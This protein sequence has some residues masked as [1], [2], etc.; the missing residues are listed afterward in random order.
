MILAREEISASAL[1][2]VLGYLAQRTNVCAKVIDRD[3]R[4]VAV[5]RRGLELLESEAR[6]VCGQIWAQFWSGEDH[7]SA[8][9]A[10]EC[11][12]GGKPNEFV[13]TFRSGNHT[14]VWE[15]EALPLEWERGTVSKVLVLST[16]L[17][18]PVEQRDP[19]HTHPDADFIA[20]LSET[21]HAL[22]NMSSVSTSG[23]N[24]LR[25]GV[26]P[27]RA[28]YLADALEDAGRRA[29]DA[30]QELAAILGKDKK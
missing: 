26:D 7:A 23:A 2:T 1:S 16:R 29:A 3:G 17:V 20:K 6:D 18:Q 22:A 15:V 13:G 9:G 11:A 25:R 27:D 14:S 28:K 30:I 21:F 19:E 4:V 5:N 24:I 8:A 10:V 12:F